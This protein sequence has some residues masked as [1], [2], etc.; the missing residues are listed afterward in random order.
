MSTHV[1]ASLPELAGQQAAEEADARGP[2]LVAHPA[3]GTTGAVAMSRVIEG[4]LFDVE[5]GDPVVLTAVSVTVAI[6]ALVPGGVPALRA[7]RN[8]P[9][10]VLRA[11]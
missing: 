4:L 1:A 8:D 9:V 2:S 5:P 6:V 7:A 10:A 3:L 11:K